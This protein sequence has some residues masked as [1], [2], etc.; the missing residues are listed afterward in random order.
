MD[1]QI[2]E[3]RVGT[4]PQHSEVVIIGTGVSGLLAG[5]RLKQ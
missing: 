5:I 2:P 4:A 3:A 1:A